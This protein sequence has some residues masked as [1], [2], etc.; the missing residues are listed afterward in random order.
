MKTIT[1]LTKRS[2]AIVALTCLAASAH[3]AT[4]TFDF[5][6][7]FGPAFQTFSDQSLYTVNNTGGAV[8][9]F[10]GADTPPVLNEFVGGGVRSNFNM[11]GDFTATVDFTIHNMPFPGSNKLNESVLS[12][13]S[14]ANPGDFALVLR[15]AESNQFVEG[16]TNAPLG[17]TPESTLTGRYR[18]LRTGSNFTGSYAVG[19]SATFNTLFSSIP[20]TSEPNGLS[21]FG[22]Q[23]ANV[24]TRSGTALD[25]SF[26]NLVVSAASFSGITAA[27]PEPSTYALMLGGLGL[28]GYVANRRRKSQIPHA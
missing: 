28:V 13:A 11:V 16:F 6:S 3:A 10:K 12:V 4:L 21:L 9:I 15:F 22:V 14:S 18:I 25:I 2:I 20:I 26:D 5:D 7:G 24:G 17:L 1:A 8:R 19:N 23:G 27:V